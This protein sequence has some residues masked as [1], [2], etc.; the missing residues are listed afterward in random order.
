ME[1][2]TE[3][4]AGPGTGVPFFESEI[5]TVE[6]AVKL[7]QTSSFY[8]QGR[9]A[10][11]SLLAQLHSRLGYAQAVSYLDGRLPVFRQQLEPPTHG[12]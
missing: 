12:H 10:Y 11:D 1:P 5:E 9:G 8:S 3:A 6:H 7:V 2:H 4:A